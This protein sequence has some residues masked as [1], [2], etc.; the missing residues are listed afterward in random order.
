[1]ME[2]FWTPEA[3]RD[4]DDARSANVPQSCTAAV[5]PTA[6]SSGGLR[7]ASLFRATAYWT[8]DPS[9]SAQALI[10]STLGRRLPGGRQRTTLARA[11]CSRPTPAAAKAAS[12]FLPA[13]PT[14]PMPAASS[15]R[16]GASPTAMMCDASVCYT[17][18]DADLRAYCRATVGAR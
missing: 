7:P 16:P 3:N 13:R 8:K 4:R 2:L 10:S 6:S 17:I 18:M 11:Y 14:K 15:S 9:H 1:M 5:C 12:R